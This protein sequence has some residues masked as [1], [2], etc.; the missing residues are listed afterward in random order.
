MRCSGWSSLAISACNV[1]ALALVVSA[2][3]GAHVTAP[4][5][6][7]SASDT[8]ELDLL[9]PNERKAPMT[10]FVVVVPA[11]FRIVSAS[12]T[13]GWNAGADGKVASWHNG[14][15]AP[16]AETTFALELEAPSEPGPATLRTQQHYPNGRVVR[17]DVGLTVTPVS[18]TAPAQNLGWAVISGLLG[19]LALTAVGVLLW[20]RRTAALS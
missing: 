15:L 6:F 1:V 2:P 9:V 10:G 16:G 20:R 12:S 19:L 8:D 11:D 14:T 3:A 17:W 18:E 7:L 13:D 5:P 4:R